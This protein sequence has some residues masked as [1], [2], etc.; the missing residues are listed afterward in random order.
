MLDTYGWILTQNDEPENGLALLREAFAR[1]S[2]NPEVRYHIGVALRILGRDQEA[3]EELKAA[4][5][6]GKTFTS[7]E[8]AVKLIQELRV[9]LA[10][11]G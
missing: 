4:I 2:T 9:S 11:Q 7:E 1:S 3:L 8:D 5:D 10:D 6:S